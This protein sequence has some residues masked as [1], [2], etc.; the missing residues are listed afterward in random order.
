MIIMLSTSGM[1]LS[2]E[3]AQVL[4]NVSYLIAQLPVSFIDYF[5]WNTDVSEAFATSSEL[6][7]FSFMG[8]LSLLH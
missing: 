2:N 8:Q 4:L 5:I 6:C 3:E 7:K 1:P